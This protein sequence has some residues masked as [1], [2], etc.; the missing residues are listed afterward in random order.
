MNARLGYVAG[1]DGLRAIAVSLVMV[2]HAHAPFLHTGSLGVDVFFVLSG[3]LIT[4]ILLNGAAE[5]G[6]IDV[7]TFY[8]HRFMRLTPPLF[9]LLF[10]YLLIAPFAWPNYASH[11][12]DAAMAG[13]YLSDYSLA[14]G[15]FPKM[16]R[17]T[18][19]LAVE[20]HFYLLWPFVLIVLRPH[21]TRTILGV[22]AAIYVLA[23]LWRVY[24]AATQSWEAVYYRFDTRF[25]GLML[26][27]F[28]AVLMDVDWKRYFRPGVLAL[29]A[30]S[31][32][33]VLLLILSDSTGWGHTPTLQ[34]G[35]I[36]TEVVTAIVIL[37]VMKGERFVRWLSFAPLTYFGRLSYGMYLFHYPVMLYFRDLTGWVD[38][39]VYGSI[40]AILLSALSYHTIEAWVRRWRAKRKHTV[41]PQVVP[42]LSERLSSAG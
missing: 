19:S 29:S 40:S 13:L 23:T 15:E 34:Y 3:F 16:L 35:V 36:G 32:L 10:I 38:A 30:L 5:S 12:R 2:S 11:G 21:K 14:I 25:S 28:V 31:G 33:F 4:R 42:G 37:A 18:W 17:H 26:G 39:L 20:E 27:A 24:C 41:P 8:V 6:R 1:L 7:K 9:L 22:M